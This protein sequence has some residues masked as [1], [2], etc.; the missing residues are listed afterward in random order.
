[1]KRNNEVIISKINEIGTEE[2]KY[3]LFNYP[4]GPVFISK[5]WELKRITLA[6]GHIERYDTIKAPSLI[7]GIGAIQKDNSI[8]TSG[9]LYIFRNNKIYEADM[10]EIAK[11]VND[12][13]LNAIIN[14]THELRFIR[15]SLTSA[16]IV[17]GGFGLLTYVGFI[18]INSPSASSING[19]TRNGA[20]QI[21][22]ANITYRHT[23]GSY[24]ML[25]GLG[26]EA[27]SLVVKLNEVKHAHLVVKV[28]NEI[29]QKQR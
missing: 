27:L 14:R 10:L 2:I 24:F 5:K 25:G 4:E 28:Y 23:V 15:K 22:N 11:N 18:P 13:K 19:S 7:S 16:A 3:R 1:V 9:Q 20:R 12:K 26:C 21:R 6:N 8:I 29:V 17:A